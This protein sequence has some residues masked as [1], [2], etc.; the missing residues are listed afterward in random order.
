VS[1]VDA[2]FKK[3]DIRGL[4]GTEIT[5]E[6]VAAIAA[7]FVDVLDLAGKSVVVGYDM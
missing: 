5:P 3:Y 2:I 6:K 4:V 1:T 7:S